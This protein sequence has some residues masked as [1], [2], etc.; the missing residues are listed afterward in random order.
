MQNRHHAKMYV[1]YHNTL[2]DSF[3]IWISWF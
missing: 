2:L 1:V 3:R